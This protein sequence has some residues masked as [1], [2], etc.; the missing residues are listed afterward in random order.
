[1]SNHEKEP[2]LSSIKKNLF[3]EI[4]INT[5]TEILDSMMVNTLKPNNISQSKSIYSTINI[6][7]FQHFNS[8]FFY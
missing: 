7:S 8:G 4:E 6:E 1:M 5:N 3:D 2:I